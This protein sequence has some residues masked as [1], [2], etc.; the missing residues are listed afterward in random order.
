MT[1]CIRVRYGG[2]SNLS[3]NRSH[4]VETVARNAL[5]ATLS[6]VL[7]SVSARI[8]GDLTREGYTDFTMTRLSVSASNFML[9][10]TEPIVTIPFEPQNDDDSNFAVEQKDLSASLSGIVYNGYCVRV[11]SPVGATEQET[12]NF[13]NSVRRIFA[14]I[15]TLAFGAGLTAGNA[16]L[17]SVSSDDTSTFSIAVGSVDHTVE[18]FADSSAERDACG[19][20]IRYHPDSSN[21][22][23]IPRAP[24]NGQEREIQRQAVFTANNSDDGSKIITSDFD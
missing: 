12:V 11:W 13:M 24:L 16:A 9:A 5:F 8:I 15:G 14:E 2:L 21:K 6:T 4:A 22:F 10:G 1:T 3:P 17:G 20:V 23:R 19:N 7:F 18:G